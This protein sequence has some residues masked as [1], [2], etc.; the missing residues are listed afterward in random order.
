MAHASREKSLCLISGLPMNPKKI[1]PDNAFIHYLNIFR[2]KIAKD[3]IRMLLFLHSS[4]AEQFM[5]TAGDL[6]DF[7]HGTY[8]LERKNETL[9]KTHWDGVEK[10][11]D[12]LNAR[13]RD[14][15]LKHISNV[16]ALVDNT[17]ESE[18]KA[19]LLADLVNWLRRRHTYA[20]A[21]GIAY[22]AVHYTKSKRNSLRAEIEFEL[23]ECLRLNSDLSEALGH[24]KQS[25]EIIREVGDK[26][27]E[28]ATCY[29]LA[30]EWERRQNIKKAIHYLAKAVDIEEATGHSD[31]VADKA[32]LVKL[33]RKQQNNDT[34]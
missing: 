16:R 19:R 7:R 2:D 30:M 13:D 20:L 6:W 11:A 15:I 5:A 21:I 23:G 17:E 33:I 26:A 1:E 4:N 25:L 8:W 27:G 34:L 9:P 24:Y 28:A 3:R 12:E 31:F 14:K 18:K 22:H 32:Y 10:K 29:N